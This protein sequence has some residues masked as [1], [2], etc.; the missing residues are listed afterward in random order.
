MAGQGLK[1][2]VL[3]DAAVPAVG[4]RTVPNGAQL[5]VHRVA[6]P[7]RR[8]GHTGVSSPPGRCGDD[9]VEFVF[10]VS[11]AG[12][13][14]W[15]I[16]RGHAAFLAL[17]ARL[18]G[19]CPPGTALPVLPASSS[20]P[21]SRSTV[22]SLFRRDR[23]EEELAGQL[24]AYLTTLLASPRLRERPEVQAFLEIP[25]SR[26]S[27]PDAES[28]PGGIC[29]GL[30]RRLIALLR[31]EEE[32]TVIVEDANLE[33]VQQRRQALCEHYRG[34]LRHNRSSPQEF[35][36]ERPVGTMR[37]SLSEPSEVQ[38]SETPAS[39]YAP[40]PLA[41]SKREVFLPKDSKLVEWK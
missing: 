10:E 41:R 7:L 39:E 16:Q 29:R 17:H 27:G 24:E 35:V 33:T 30:C 20:F 38:V 25:S 1:E 5:L 4:S 28:S 31:S 8:Q 18:E 11:G 32:E 9:D 19:A 34:Q 22:Q 40:S 2:P 12:L 14:P 36:S 26:E 15:C 13:Q 23:S 3:L 6:S 37:R 21:S